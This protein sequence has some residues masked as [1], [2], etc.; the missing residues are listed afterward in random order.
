LFGA[1]LAVVALTQTASPARAQFTPPVAKPSPETL[2][3][4]QCAT[5]HTLNAADPPRQGPTLAG[6][7]GRRAGSVPGFAYSAGFANAD[8]RWDAGRL[9]AWL[10]RPQAVI[11]GAVMPYAQSNADIRHAII[12]YLEAQQQ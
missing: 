12:S 1:T 8:F 5:C 4:N 9:D 2:F 7:I 3:R 6:V 11:P 10:T